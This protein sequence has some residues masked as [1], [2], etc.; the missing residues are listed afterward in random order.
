[1]VLNQTI[2][3]MFYNYVLL[4]IWQWRLFTCSGF[5]IYQYDSYNDAEKIGVKKVRTHECTVVFPLF[6]FTINTLQNIYTYLYTFI[7]QLEKN[8]YEIGIR[9]LTFLFHAFLRYWWVANSIKPKQLASYSHTDFCFMLLHQCS[10]LWRVK[11]HD[12]NTCIWRTLF[13]VTGW[14]SLILL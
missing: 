5:N 6:H 4:N 10:L 13:G 3:F 12:Q 1:M 7:G 2:L 8:T 14:I 9:W 11:Y